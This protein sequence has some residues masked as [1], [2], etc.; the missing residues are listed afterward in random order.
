MQKNLVLGDSS[1]NRSPNR[2]IFRTPSI[3]PSNIRLARSLV[4]VVFHRKRGSVAGTKLGVHRMSPQHT[5]HPHSGHGSTG[6][7]L[8]VGYFVFFPRCQAHTRQSTPIHR[9]V[10]VLRQGARARAFFLRKHGRATS[11]SPCCFDSPVSPA[12][13]FVP[14]KP[15]S[16]WR[17]GRWNPANRCVAWW[18]NSERW[19]TSGRCPKVVRHQVALICG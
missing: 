18:G 2:W 19:K 10:L 3:H 4:M 7:A 16:P 13:T 14:D 5:L 6:N 8:F 1:E 17:T 12:A 11:R 15:Q 9:H